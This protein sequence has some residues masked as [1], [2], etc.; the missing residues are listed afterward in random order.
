MSKIA[1]FGSIIFQR[2]RKGSARLVASPVLR[3]C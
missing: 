1:I 3:P 2:E